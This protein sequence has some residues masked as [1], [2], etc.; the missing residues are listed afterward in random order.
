ML[1]FSTYLGMFLASLAKPHLFAVHELKHEYLP[2]GRNLFPTAYDDRMLHH[3]VAPPRLSACSSLV[4]TKR[5]KS[6]EQW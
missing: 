4:V 3:V 6:L 2:R 5:A 1:S